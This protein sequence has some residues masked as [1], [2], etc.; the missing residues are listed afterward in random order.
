LDIANELAVIY[1]L[2]DI[3]ADVVL[4]INMKMHPLTR[5]DRALVCALRIEKEQKTLRMMKEFSF[6]TMEIQ[7]FERFN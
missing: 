2:C 3:I 4:V 5:D 6:E 1:V 7:Y